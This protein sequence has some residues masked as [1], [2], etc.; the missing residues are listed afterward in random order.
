VRA[1]GIENGQAGSTPARLHSV[2]HRSPGEADEREPRESPEFFHDLNLDQIVES[3][4]AG[5]KDYD[6]RPFFHA[7]LHDLDAVAYRQEVMRDLDGQPLLQVVRRFAESMR[8]MRLHLTG[9]R[10][11]SYRYEKLRWFLAAAETYAGAVE[12]L[13]QELR[14][15]TLASRGMRALREHVERYRASRCFEQLME[16]ARQVATALAAIRY[17]VLV[18]GGTVT[19]RRYGE[20]ADY[21]AQVEAT[22]EKF[23]RGAVKDYTVA[24]KDAA[25]MN[26]IEAQIVERVALLYPEAF[27]ALESF[28]ERYAGFVDDTLA[29]FDREVHFYI[30]WLVH[31]DALRATGLR[32]CHPELTDRDKEVSA[33]Q[34]FDLA[35]AR[36]LVSEQAAVVPNDFFLRGAERI[37]VVT[38]P[39]NGGKTTFARMFGQMHYL[40]SLGLPVP[41]TRAR[42]FL[43][44]R[45]FAHFERHEDITNLRGKLQDDL[46]RI[47]RVLDAATPRSIVI[48]NEIFSSTTLEDAVFLSR[49]IIGRLSRLDALGVCV[50]F[51]SELASFDEKTVSMVSTVDPDD[52]AVR[53]YKVVRRPADGLAYALA[54][55]RKHRV[56][57]DELIERIP[58]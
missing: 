13:Q 12:R 11:L 45:M 29:R 56:T 32:F 20:E 8:Q 14:P 21:T 1:S 38:G 31:I 4:T 3:V 53:T 50:T 16:E 51:L 7:P 10:N 26:H 44:D 34:A 22:F 33:Q 15:L 48:L 52:P 19:V 24:Y 5:W 17:G 54:I 36:K 58:P 35:L 6:L 25:G 42:L 9:A 40:A 2:L 47:R 57:H 28:H 55:A 37:F 23:R 46:V 41:G 39:N 30:A 27:R 43:C 18:H 49:K